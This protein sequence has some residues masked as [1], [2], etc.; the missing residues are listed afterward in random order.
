MATVDLSRMQFWQPPL[1]PLSSKRHTASPHIRRNGTS[2]LVT[3]S[4]NLPAS[5]HNKANEA[6]MRNDQV[7]SAVAATLH[8]GCNIA[9]Q[10]EDDAV[11]AG[12]IGEYSS[13]ELV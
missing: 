8:Q 4:D 1:N 6:L 11:E 10:H 2:S 3:S 12:M 13:I 5:L 9:F 7:K